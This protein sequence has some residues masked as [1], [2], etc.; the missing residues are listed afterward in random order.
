M[1]DATAITPEELRQLPAFYVYEHWRLDTNAC[2]YVGKGIGRR[3]WDM[4]KRNPHH[5]NITEK[6]GDQVDVV[7]VAERLPETEAFK[8]ETERIAHWR[9]AGYQL[10]NLTNG[11][12]GASG[13]SVSAETK[14][15]ISKAHKGKTLS[16]EHRIKLSE[17]QFRR[18]KNPE[19]RARAG[20]RSK[21][22]KQS[23]ETVAKRAAKLRGRK[24]PQAFCDAIG[25]RMRGKTVSEATRGKIRE[26]LLGRVVSEEIKRKK[27]LYNPANRAVRCL[28]TGLV[29]VSASE[30]A[31][32]LNVSKTH[33]AEICR[34]NSVRKSAKG[35]RF[36][37]VGGRLASGG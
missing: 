6:I 7:I 32:V 36:E 13:F 26:A 27:Q 19:E 14:A 22:R 1:S 34:G 21:G 20:G 11:G 8:L 12:E 17:A 30:A 28:N 16:S 10:A 35:Y 24:M 33:V 15:R 29:Y 4:R 5:R 18:F 9:A 2:F 37:Y 23:A 31:R 3:A 25:D